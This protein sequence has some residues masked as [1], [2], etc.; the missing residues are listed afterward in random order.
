MKSAL[1]SSM[2]L[3]S[4]AF[5]TNTLYGDI[6]MQLSL[7]D[8]TG[9]VT[10]N[11]LESVPVMS[12]P[13]SWDIFPSVTSVGAFDVGFTTAGSVIHDGSLWNLHLHLDV[14]NNDTT[15]RE[16]EVMLTA[17]NLSIADPAAA[18][19]LT[20][21]IGG[22]ASP[23][24]DDVT[25]TFIASFDAANGA[26]SFPVGTTEV[27]APLTGSPFSQSGDMLLAGLFEDD[28]SLSQKVTI[29]N[30][31]P[32]QT[33][34]FDSESILAQP[35]IEPVVPEP[36][37]IVLFCLGASGLYG[38]VRRRRTGIATRPHQHDL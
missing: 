2:L 5:S 20:S 25:H 7:K 38:Y 27:F 19:V 4:I 16:F 30:I 21:G 36:V 17:Q 34:S 1:W 33:I 29:T 37:S 11:D 9:G 18:Q 8:V 12:P 23:S 3:L 15:A 22:I 24:T 6:V 32:G 26:Y 13:F 28:F 14:T 35:E 10:N 31:A